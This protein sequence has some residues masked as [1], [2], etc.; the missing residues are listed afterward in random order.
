M[1]YHPLPLCCTLVSFAQAHNSPVVAPNITPK[2]SIDCALE[3][4]RPK[5]ERRQMRRE[6]KV[7]ASGNTSRYETNSQYSL[8]ACFTHDTHRTAYSS[9]SWNGPRAVE[10]RTQQLS[11]MFPPS[12]SWDRRR[13]ASH[14]TFSS[15]CVNDLCEKSTSPM[16]CTEP[17]V[18]CDSLSVKRCRPLLVVQ[19]TM[20][21][22]E[23]PKKNSHCTAQK[24]SIIGHDH[25]TS[26]CLPSCNSTFRNKT[27]C[28]PQF[29]ALLWQR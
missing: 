4:K 16:T 10:T 28:I 27:A 8:Y 7:Q 12:G 3:R 25:S 17:F 19:V 13:L 5:G 20:F 18:F 6:K 15:S 24:R 1:Q 22:G 11:A 26:L 14:K 9:A 21:L 29:P 2:T 23:A